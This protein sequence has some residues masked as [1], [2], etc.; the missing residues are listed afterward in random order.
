M[1]IPRIKITFDIP[2]DF[3]KVLD[4]FDQRLRNHILRQCIRSAIVPPKNALKA[5]TMSLINSTGKFETRSTPYSQSSGATMRAIDTKVKQSKRNRNRLYGIVGVNKKLV[6]AFA[7]L[8]EGSSRKNPKSTRLQLSL[9]ILLRKDV[10]GNPVFSRRHKPKQ[11]RSYLKTRHG[12][13]GTQLYEGM[14]FRRRKPAKYF[15]ILERGFKGPGKRSFVGYRM[16]EAAARNTLPQALQIFKD[17]LEHFLK[18]V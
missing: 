15:H 13:K 16:V 12:R 10:N 5:W 2:K 3:Q 1:T 14:H 8:G 7:D 11:V 4:S 17:R 18:N 6:E 9:G